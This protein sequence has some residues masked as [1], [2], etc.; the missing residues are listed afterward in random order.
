[1]PNRRQCFVNV[2]TVKTV[3]RDL[4]TLGRHAEEHALAASGVNHASLCEKPAAVNH[5]KEIP[6]KI[7]DER[8]RE[9]LPNLPPALQVVGQRRSPHHLLRVGASKC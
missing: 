2:G 7:G 4:A 8:W 6:H 9:K 5:L 1:M 3:R